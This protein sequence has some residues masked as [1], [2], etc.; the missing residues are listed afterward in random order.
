MDEDEILAFH[1]KHYKEAGLRW[2][3]N[4]VGIEKIA[5]PANHKT[6]SERKKEHQHN[7]PPRNF[8]KE[9]FGGNYSVVE[10]FEDGFHSNLEINYHVEV[11]IHEK[12]DETI[13][14]IACKNF[15]KNGAAADDKMSSLSIACMEAVSPIG[16]NINKMGRLVKLAHP[17]VY[18]KRF[19][20]KRSDIEDFF[21]GE[22]AN[23]L[24][25]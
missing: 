21:V 9:F 13:V 20:E 5:V 25:K 14:E 1:H 19:S 4:F 17:E 15:L 11:N 22:M 16:L 8:N 10:K 24:F 2:F 18:T 3:N 12:N 6:K 23:F 7:F